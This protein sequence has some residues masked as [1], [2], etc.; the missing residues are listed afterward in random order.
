MTRPGPLVLAHR[1][2]RGIAPENTLIAFERAMAMGADG[3]ELDVTLSADHVPVVI[4]D[5]TLDR[6]TSGSGPVHHQTLA[7]LQALDAGSWF[8]D[9]FRA[10]RIPTLAEAIDLVGRRGLINVELK[11]GQGS[12]GLPERVLAVIGRPRFEQVII[13]SFSPW[14]LRETRRLAPLLRLGLLS[15][16]PGGSLLRGLAGPVAAYHPPFAAID[17]PFVS[18]AHAQGRQVNVWTVNETADI[19]TMINFGVDSIITDYPDRV[20]AALTQ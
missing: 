6:T 5:S 16:G 17:A 7:Q 19:Q 15:V 13:S 8:G 2:A 1:G 11:A 10:A 12:R 18:R 20:I 4:H 9:E 3:I 14:L